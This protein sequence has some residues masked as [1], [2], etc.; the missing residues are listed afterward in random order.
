[1][2]SLATRSWCYWVGNG[3]FKG[4]LYAGSALPGEALAYVGL[5]EGNR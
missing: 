2:N 5:P 4:D 1:M 3:I